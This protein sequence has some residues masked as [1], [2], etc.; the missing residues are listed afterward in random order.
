MTTWWQTGVIYQI[1]PRSFMDS[2]S[3]GIGDLNGIT[4][5]LDHLEWLGVD[6]I[7]L[8]PMYPSPWKDGGYDV[9]DYTNVH[10]DFGTLD[11]FDR[12][13]READA[14]N[15]RVILDLVP[16]HT[17]DQHQWF[18]ESRSSRDNPKAD[19][20][21]WRD[22]KP[23]GSPP[24]NWTAFFADES[25]WEYDETRGQ[26][27]LHSFLKEQPDLNWRNPEVRAAMYDS[28]RFWLDRGV[29]GFRVDVIDI[30]LKDA[31]LRDDP[32]NP[33]YD[34]EVNIP[35][36][37]TLH[38]HSAYLDEVHEIIREMRQVIDEYEDRVFIGELTYE[39]TLDKYVS[40]FG[41]NN[42]ELMIPFNFKPLEMTL[43]GKTATAEQLQ[44]YINRFEAALG[45]GRQGNWV[46][47]NH[48]VPRLA[49]RVGPQ[50]RAYA[51]LMLTLRGTPFIFQGEEIGMTNVDVP[52]EKMQDP[53]GINVPGMGRDICR[54]PVQWDATPTVGF[55]DPDVQPWLPVG[56]NIDT[57]NVE[58]QRDDPTSM[59]T[60]YRRL[61]ELRRAL[62]ALNQ[63]LFYP[64][65][66][67]PPG[68]IAYSRQFNDQRFVIV[69]NFTEDAREMSVTG[70][71]VGHVILSTLLDRDENSDLTALTLRPYEGVLIEIPAGTQAMPRIEIDP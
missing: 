54:T 56:D 38:I 55:T 27:Y 60:L 30:M 69:L 64:I 42:D 23:D 24:N 10:P 32:P 66:D 17:S 47:G 52:P 63:G 68:I 43:W 61:I 26:Y 21:I 9:A 35:R 53:F 50:A 59:L 67:L 31:E 44:A 48:D 25:S 20:Y 4:S 3:D 5:R 49:S 62:T 40:Y 41:P 13:I 28:I 70:F 33:D 39:I 57:I 58:A 34:P 7:W 65:N 45:P 1:Y 14:H 6:A 22:P 16:N 51:M 12:L 37:R 2:N 46:F 15:I 11:D 36:D 29:G 71:E 19:W 8:S 18:I